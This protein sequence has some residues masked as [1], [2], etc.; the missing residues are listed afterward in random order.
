MLK[1]VMQELLQ[2]EHIEVGLEQ[3]LLLKRKE[4]T[5]VSGRA[6]QLRKDRKILLCGEKTY[7]HFLRLKIDSATGI[8]YFFQ[9]KRT[10]ISYTEI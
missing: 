2:E 1:Q 4:E 5:K 9:T 8:P 10:L 7:P 3:I 6:A